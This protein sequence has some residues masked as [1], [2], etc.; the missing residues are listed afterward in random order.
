[1]RYLLPL[2]VW[3]VDVIRLYVR[4]G[5]AYLLLV[6]VVCSFDSAAKLGGAASA[7]RFTKKANNKSTVL[8]LKFISNY[9]LGLDKAKVIFLLEMAKK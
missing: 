1:M 4:M 5:A 3:S 2:I 7:V 6:G 9:W 8:A